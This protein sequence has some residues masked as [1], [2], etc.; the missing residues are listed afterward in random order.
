M[1]ETP[2]PFNPA[3]PPT[4]KK[5]VNPIIWILVALAASCFVCIILGVV[6]FFSGI[7]QVGAYAGCPLTMGVANKA[8][9]DYVKDHGT[10]PSAETW[11]TDT[12][13]AY[14]K[15]YEKMKSEMKDAG[16]FKDIISLPA[17]GEQFVCFDGKVKTGICYNSDLAGKKPSDFKD[18][19][20]EI[21]LFEA[22]SVAI[23]NHGPYEKVTKKSDQQI[24]GQERKYYTWPY[25]QDINSKESGVT[26]STQD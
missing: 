4:A 21:C 19:S 1:A 13:E 20:N 14:T 12:Q 5:S 7:K 6:M 17:P 24:F 15:E 25:G 8:I 3:G 23:N 10:F 2:P 11:Q 9:R 26:I 16:L 18:V 22:D